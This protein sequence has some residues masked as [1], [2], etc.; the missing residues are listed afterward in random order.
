MSMQSGDC[1]EA[2]LEND[3]MGV[4]GLCRCMTIPTGPHSSHL[5]HDPNPFRPQYPNDIDIFLLGLRES[6]TRSDGSRISGF[7]PS[8]P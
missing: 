5:R 7:V 3:E 8:N 2:R 6:G 4:T 1:R